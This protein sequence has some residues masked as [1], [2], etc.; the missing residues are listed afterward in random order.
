MTGCVASSVDRM[1]QESA[2]L[3][4][5]R[6][7]LQDT[8]ALTSMRRARL[9]LVDKNTETTRQLSVSVKGCREG[10]TT[11]CAPR[12]IVFVLMSILTLSGVSSVSFP[13][14]AMRRQE[15]ITNFFI[16]FCQSH[17]FTKILDVGPGGPISVFPLA[18]HTVDYRAF[19]FPNISSNIV[20]IVLDFDQER[21]PFPDKYFDFIYSRHVLEVILVVDHDFN[22]KSI[23]SG[24][25]QPNGF[26]QRDDS[27]F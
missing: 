14:I 7:C 23:P 18:T 3:I 10:K 16:N 15:D 9:I 20:Q 6:C 27:C 19:D 4:Q 26:I 11:Q 8:I 2:S 17:H 24:S 12:M 22:F 25:S 1:V 5:G 21:L 13:P